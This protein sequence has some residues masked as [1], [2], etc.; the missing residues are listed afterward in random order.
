MEGMLKNKKRKNK[1]HEAEKSKKKSQMVSLSCESSASSFDTP[2][3]EPKFDVDLSEDG[4]FSSSMPEFSVHLGRG[5]ILTMKEYQSSKYM[6][7]SR[8]TN[9]RITNRFNLPASLKD[10][11]KEAIKLAADHASKYN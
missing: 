2:P 7:F 11:L 1:E 5:Y 6:C 8:E 4:N 9:G 10:N 3:T